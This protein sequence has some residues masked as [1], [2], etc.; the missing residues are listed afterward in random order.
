MAKVIVNKNINFINNANIKLK[1]LSGTSWLNFFDA[2]GRVEGNNKYD[3]ANGQ[4]YYGI[5][6]QGSAVLTDINFY[7][8]FGKVLNISTL[9]EFQKNP[10][11]QE[12]AVLMEFAGIPSKLVGKNFTSKYNATKKA[13]SDY[14]NK[15]S[16][17]LSALLGKT[18]TIKWSGTDLKQTFTI[19]KGSISGAAHLI[20]QGS[21][22]SALKDIYGNAFDSNDG[23]L[24]TTT[25]T[26]NPTKTTYADGNNISFAT[27]MSLF[28]GYSI[29]TLISANSSIEGSEFNF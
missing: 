26:L 25:I 13:M 20:G 19:D 6:Q 2:I 10:I 14:E 1:G 27:Y 29:D 7:N 24:I 15:N 12:M 28:D 18:F 3:I 23:H 4:G 21:L 5:Y 9:S 11:A 22:A 16:K 17:M 8:S